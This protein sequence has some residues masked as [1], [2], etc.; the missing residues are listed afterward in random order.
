M[1]K[2]ERLQSEEAEYCGPETKLLAER[3]LQITGV[4]HGGGGLL[5][6]K[7]FYVEKLLDIKA[8]RR[9]SPYES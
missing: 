6:A 1:P 2:R 9:P 5:N 8:E 4:A 7:M 3:F